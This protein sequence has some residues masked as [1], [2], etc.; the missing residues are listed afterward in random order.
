MSEVVDAALRRSRRVVGDV[1]AFLFARAFLVFQTHSDRRCRL[2]TFARKAQQRPSCTA[3]LLVPSGEPS[4]K[5]LLLVILAVDG[6]RW[7]G[8]LNRV[9]GLRG[10]W[11][12]GVVFI[13]GDVGGWYRLWRHDLKVAFERIAVD[14]R[15]IRAPSVVVLRRAPHGLDG[16]AALSISALVELEG[17]V[18]R[19][20]RCESHTGTRSDPPAAD[21]RLTRPTRSTAR[22]ASRSRVR[23]SQSLPRLVWPGPMEEEVSRGAERWHT[24][25]D[26]RQP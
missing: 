12:A 26:Y 6:G 7:S 19:G 5:Y 15:I 13:G 3:P 2:Q 8:E 25:N 18:G 16:Q 4:G 17:A 21:W 22:T 9:G 14:Y 11:S 10:W 20:R 24:S 1:G 23:L